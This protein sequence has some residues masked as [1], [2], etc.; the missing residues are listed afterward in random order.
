MSYVHAGKR[1]TPHKQPGRKIHDK[2]A[3]RLIRFN[4][5][6]D[7]ARSIRRH[8]AKQLDHESMGARL[9]R[10]RYER[11]MFC[12]KY[13][14]NSHERQAVTAMLVKDWQE[15][16]EEAQKSAAAKFKA[17]HPKPTPRSRPVKP[18]SD[19]PKG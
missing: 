14:T 8:G 13:C 11:M 2:A 10:F 16:E 4:S 6:R 12:A 15:R 17:K 9:A 18:T 1:F 7:S 19:E 5:M 3:R